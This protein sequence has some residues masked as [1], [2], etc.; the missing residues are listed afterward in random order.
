MNKLREQVE[1]IIRIHWSR[2]NN[3]TAY[4]TADK[5]ITLILDEVKGLFYDDENLYMYTSEQVRKRIDN[6]RG[7]DEQ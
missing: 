1:Q 7:S 5:L 4:N 3:T 6:L 2:K